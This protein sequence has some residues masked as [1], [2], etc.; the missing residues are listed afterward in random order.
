MDRDHTIAE[1]ED[2]MVDA[3][4]LDYLDLHIVM[5]IAE[6]EVGPDD[7]QAVED[8]ALAAIERMLRDGRLD[9]GYLEPPGEFRSW[10]LA[11]DAAMARIRAGLAELTEPV[12]NGEVA[13]FELVEQEAR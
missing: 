7:P 3:G 10:Q 12:F 9:A 8:L 13:W 1:I 2:V 5:R 6:N 11:P 4:R